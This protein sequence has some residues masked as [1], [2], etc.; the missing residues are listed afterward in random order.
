MMRDNLHRLRLPPAK[1]KAHGREFRHIEELFD[2]LLR[3]RAFPQ[4][5]RA[6]ERLKIR[7]DR[8]A[9]PDPRR[10]VV[11]VHQIDGDRPATELADLTLKL[12]RAMHLR[13]GETSSGV[14]VPRIIRV[15]DASHPALL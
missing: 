2:N 8:K 14:S 11:A 13:A 3:L 15:H 9:A 10:D 1:R 12:P 7:H 4:I 6:A 5:A